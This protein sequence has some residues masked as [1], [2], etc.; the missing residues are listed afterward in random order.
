MYEK[1]NVW[2]YFLNRNK[3]FKQQ[4]EFQE[5]WENHSW[6]EPWLKMCWKRKIGLSLNLIG[7]LKKE[8]RNWSTAFIWIKFMPNCEREKD[9]YVSFVLNVL[10][11]VHLNNVHTHTQ[12]QHK[13]FNIWFK[14]RK[15]TEWKTYTFVSKYG[16]NFKTKSLESINRLDFSV[17][18]I[19]LLS[20][21]NFQ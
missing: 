18:I 5:E 16:N 17:A 15:K 12:N 21:L 2:E 4:N 3:H 13:R 19:C 6:K 8:I 11:I 1:Q 20:S 10:W 7:S 14:A 9:K